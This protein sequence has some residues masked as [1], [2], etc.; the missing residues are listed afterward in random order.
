MVAKHTKE[1]ELRREPSIDGWSDVDV[2]TEEF[3]GV[4]GVCHGS[5]KTPDPERQGC[6]EPCWNC[7]GDG[8]SEL[9]E[10]DGWKVYDT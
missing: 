3:Y 8:M 9:D 10:P 7:G 5:G 4:C 6:S 2:P 1:D